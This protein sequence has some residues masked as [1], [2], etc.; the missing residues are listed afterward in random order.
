M[1][2][3]ECETCHAVENTA[4]ANFWQATCEKRPALCS[5][6]DPEIGKWHGQFEKLTREEFERRYP[7]ER[8]EYTAEPSITCPRCQLR[9]YNPNDIRE[10]YC[11][12]C[13]DWHVNMVGD[14]LRGP[15]RR[16]L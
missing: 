13:H 16:T 3:F 15:S 5:A 14:A 10:R 2:L 12:R 7:G 11:G 6:C 1:P 4:L 8:I 9:S